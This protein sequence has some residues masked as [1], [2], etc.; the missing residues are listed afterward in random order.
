MVKQN[1]H[2]VVVSVKVLKDQMEKSIVQIVTTK[3]GA[4]I[5][6]NE[7]QYTPMIRI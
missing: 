1:V 5:R 2:I 7:L 3:N 6:G 4:N